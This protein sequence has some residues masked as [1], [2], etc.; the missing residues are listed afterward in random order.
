MIWTVVIAS[1]PALGILVLMYFLWPRI[2]FAPTFYD[3]RARLRDQPERFRM[4]ELPVGRGI[5]L[6][7][8]AYAPDSPACTMLFFGGR[9]HDSVA[10]VA[11]LCET[12]PAW[13]IVA[14]NYRGYGRSGGTPTQDDVL[15]DAE[16]IV[17]FVET[18][19]GEVMIMGYSL[20]A[21][22]A[23]YTAARKAPKKLVL[24]AP[25]YDIHS[26]VKVRIPRWPSWLVRWRFDTA[27]HLSRVSAPVALFASADDTLVPLG[28]TRALSAH[29]AHL[30]VYKVY[31]G[32]NHA[33]ILGSEAFA[34]DASE[35]C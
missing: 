34:A 31:S 19:D 21:A 22:V 29:A 3:N 14:F 11:R 33:D 30:A 15:A 12:F 4:L 23:A 24:V 9:E 28:Q 27:T 8:V 16:Q 26:L 13:R 7:G 1:M 5:S 17:R 32:Y 10:L 20:G 25:F 2:I 6:E 35:L 18:H